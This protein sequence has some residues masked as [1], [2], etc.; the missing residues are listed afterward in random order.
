ML[1]VTLAANLFC[2]WIF[3]SNEE[4]ILSAMVKA[5]DKL[6]LGNKMANS[7]PPISGNCI[8]ISCFS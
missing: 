6:V 4:R 7:S 8:R 5:P 2:L 3:P 1:T